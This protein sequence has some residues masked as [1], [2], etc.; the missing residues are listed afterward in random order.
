[1]EKIIDYTKLNYD[2]LV[3]EI[4]K[5][6]IVIELD[7][8]SI[9][10]EEDFELVMKNDI[11]ICTCKG[12]YV[13]HRKSGIE[14]ILI[15]KTLNEKAKKRILHEEYGHF[16]TSTGNILNQ[17]NVQN[18]KQEIRALDYAIETFLPLQRVY[19]AYLS[20]SEE[21]NDFE[22]ADNL[23]IPLDYLSELFTF[24]QRKGLI[25]QR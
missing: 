10:L 8:K 9:D 23:D 7:L 22:I 21:K 24:Y 11:C 1:M 15:E 16:K 19:E 13:K 12:L 5:E 2:E 18:R 25:P 6:I 4:T 14:F 20:A 17:D 3:M